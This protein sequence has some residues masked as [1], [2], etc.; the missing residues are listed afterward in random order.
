MTISSL[1][2]LIALTLCLVTQV[3]FAN[4]HA[5]LMRLKNAYPEMIKSVQG[6]SF[7][8]KNGEK[9]NIHDLQ[10]QKTASSPSLIAQLNQP[11]YLPNSKIHCK[12]Y[13]PTTDPGR[14][15]NTLFFEKMY[16][17]NKQAVE[18]NLVTLY[19]MPAYF[20]HHYPLQV[21]RI[22]GVNIKL[23]KVSTELESLVQKHPSYLRYLRNPGGTF[24]WRD[25]EGSKRL[26]AHSYGI[27][28]DIN[29]QQSNY[30]MWDT[31]IRSN[32]LNQHNH[33]PYKNRIPCAIVSIF[34][35]N[36]FIW[37]GKWQHYDTMH[38]EYRPEMLN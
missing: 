19:W 4:E 37:G 24:Y 21:T 20:N 15:R 30:W 11:S 5:Q 9:D 23:E 22:N 28:I 26:S 36:G 7:T 34:E 12:K 25:I 31:G 18:K 8:W 38:F 10:Y 35:K 13:I 32:K 1:L 2:A 33:I 29:S 17:K 27:A 16:G 6:D 14:T 3:A